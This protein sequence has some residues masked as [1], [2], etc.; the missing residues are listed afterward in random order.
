[1]CIHLPYFYESPTGGGYGNR[2]FW[3]QNKLPDRL[4][5]SR[6]V[7]LYTIQNL[8]YFY[9]YFFHL[10]RMCLSR[11]NTLRKGHRPSSSSPTTISEFLFKTPRFFKKYI[12]VAT[13]VLYWRRWFLLAE[14]PA[15]QFR[16]HF[17]FLTL[18]QPIRWHRVVLCIFARKKVYRVKHDNIFP[19]ICW[20]EKK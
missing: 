14:S 1:M 13:K 4:R 8:F 11:Y 12:P 2:F 17:F 20:R 9:F 18:Q 7:S 10:L 16:Y 19:S 6:W 3:N 5:I 15:G